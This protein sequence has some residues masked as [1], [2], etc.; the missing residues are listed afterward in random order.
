MRF[1][2][3]KDYRLLASTLIIFVHQIDCDRLDE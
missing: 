1:A 2:E 3:D